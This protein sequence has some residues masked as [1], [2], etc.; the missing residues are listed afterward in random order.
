MLCCDIT[1]TVKGQLIREISDREIKR[2]GKQPQFSEKCS[3]TLYP[4]VV[5]YQ[6]ANVYNVYFLIVDINLVVFERN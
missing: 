4:G 3:R 2:V 1:S 6:L 5:A